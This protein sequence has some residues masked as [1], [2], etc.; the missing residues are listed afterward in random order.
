MSRVAVVA[1]VLMLALMPSPAGAQ[2]VEFRSMTLPPLA[3]QDASDLLER[4]DM[5]DR[6]R[7]TIHEPGSS[8]TI[9]QAANENLGLGLGDWLAGKIIAALRGASGSAGGWFNPNPMRQARWIGDVLT[10]LPMTIAAAEFG[11]HVSSRY[12]DA[13]LER[14]LAAARESAPM[15]EPD[16]LDALVGWAGGVVLAGVFIGLF[17]VGIG[18]A[19]ILPAI[20]FVYWTLGLLSYLISVAESLVAIPIWVAAAAH[21]E[22]DG[23][24]SRYGQQGWFLL[25]KLALQPLLML[26]GMIVGMV[27]VGAL[28]GWVNAGLLHTLDS[29]TGWNLVSVIGFI[30]I[31]FVMMVMLIHH[32]FELVARLPNWVFEWIGFQTSRGERRAR[33]QVAGVISGGKQALGHAGNRGLRHGKRGKNPGRTAAGNQLKG[34]DGNG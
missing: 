32:S 25:L 19:F 13:A 24:H 14:A 29:S 18:L 5:V 3:P 17:V 2:T 31:Y 21:P 10:N 26:L 15:D 9:Q 8:I 20:P 30:I 34:G 4:L 11:W 22:G 12:R 33:Q 27:T 16:A 1:A 6:Y 28:G 23:F 7:E